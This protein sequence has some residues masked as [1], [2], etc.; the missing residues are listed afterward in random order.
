MIAA[1]TLSVGVFGLVQP[2]LR[3]LGI[4]PRLAEIARN[5]GC[6][7][8]RIATLGYREPSLVFLAGTD[9]VMLESGEAAVEFLKPGGCRLAFV[10]RRHEPDF[11][12]ALERAE[13][14]PLG[15]ARVG[16]FNI[17]GGRRLDIGAYAVRP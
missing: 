15:L 10:E 8:P 3:S 1:A 6:D 9:L 11:H 2:D 12:R 5:L 17:N 7:A 16:G 13:T 4:S 14:K